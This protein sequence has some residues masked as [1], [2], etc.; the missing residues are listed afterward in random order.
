[1]ST[2]TF[3][4]ALLIEQYATERGLLLPDSRL[5]AAI[6]AAKLSLE[7]T[8]RIPPSHERALAVAVNA[9]ANDLA[10]VTIEQLRAMM[11]WARFKYWATNFIDVWSNPFTKG[12]VF[13]IS[14]ACIAVIIPW[15]TYFNRLNVIVSEL[16]EIEQRENLLTLLDEAASLSSKITTPAKP[17]DPAVFES[18]SK[19]AAVAKAPAGNAKQRAAAERAAAAQAAKDKADQAARE[20][21]KTEAEAAQK[22]AEEKR[23]EQNDKTLKELQPK[24]KILRDIDSKIR[25]DST[26]VNQIL[27]IKTGEPYMV[28]M[29]LLAYGLGALENPGKYTDRLE[30]EKITESP[31]SE[32]TECKRAGT[33]SPKAPA[34]CRYFTFAKENGLWVDSTRHLQV[35]AQVRRAAEAVSILLGSAILPLLY[36]LLGAA[37]FL[38][39]NYYSLSTAPTA[40]TDYTIGGA[41]LRMG[42]GAF[43]G[44]AIGWFWVPSAKTSND[45]ALL[46]TTPL[47]LAFLAGFSIETLFSILERAIGAMKPDVP[48]EP[49]RGGPQ[50]PKEEEHPVQGHEPQLPQG[51][52]PQGGQPQPPQAGQA[53]P[54]QAGQA[55]PPQGGQMQPPAGGLPQ[56]PQVA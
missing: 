44:F 50:P 9:A 4:D 36:G 23:L 13:V 11:R 54:P 49:R 6:L 22:I 40:R 26:A 41:T 17:F 46:T 39:R 32:D 14:V 15:T 38:L 51:G 2:R 52:Q 20:K 25:L 55:H 8:G 47:A 53:Q 18:A 37:V 5:P 19:P 29:I 30:P 42:L 34:F 24:L 33:V 7:E 28:R 16:K 43:A 56:P 3:I 35:S 48:R 27:D 31:N 12:L 21:A 45:L 10:P 1:M